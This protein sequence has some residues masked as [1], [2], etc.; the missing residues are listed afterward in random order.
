MISQENAASLKK[1][2][3][4]LLV[5]K[6]KDLVRKKE[7]GEKNCL[8]GIHERANTVFALFSRIDESKLERLTNPIHAQLQRAI[9]EFLMFFSDAI[10]YDPAK[11]STKQDLFFRLDP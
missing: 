4:N 11:G 6:D 8:E 3:S 9:N 10:E 2:L 7:L 5:Y 1:A